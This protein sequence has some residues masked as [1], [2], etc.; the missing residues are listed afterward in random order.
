MSPAII[1]VA[2]KSPI[3][4]ANASAAAAAMGRLARGRLTRQKMRHSEAP[5]LRPARSHS[6]STPSSAALD[7]L[8]RRGIAWSV[9]AITAARH[10]KTRGAPVTDSHAFPILSLI[11]ISEPTRQAEI[12]YA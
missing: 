5:R 6:R 12:S 11:H 8:I 10:V 2:P 4:R 1:K 9:E 3:D 7:D